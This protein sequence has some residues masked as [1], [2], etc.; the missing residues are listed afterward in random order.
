MENKLEHVHEWE[1]CGD[2]YEHGYVCYGCTEVMGSD[3][4]QIARCLNATERFVTFMEEY[5]SI[6]G[7][8]ES[9]RSD[10]EED[11]ILKAIYADI[12]EGKD[13]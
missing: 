3:D 6:R 2:E 8:I 11:R 7:K 5:Y 12:L 9:L 4:P 13:E 1:L 10:T